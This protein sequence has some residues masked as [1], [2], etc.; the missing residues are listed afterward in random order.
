MS[1]DFLSDVG[2]SV[3]ELDLLGWLGLTEEELSMPRGSADAEGRHFGVLDLLRQLFGAEQ[4]GG[5]PPMEAVIGEAKIR[6]HQEA[7]IGEAR[8][9][10]DASKNAANQA[11]IDETIMNNQ[12]SEED[13]AKNAENIRF[14]NDL[15][16]S[17]NQ[18]LI[19]QM[20]MADYPEPIR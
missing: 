2:N 10:D 18:R 3:G 11:M 20:I 13:E 16:N 14:Q 7:V 15:K 6:P 9:T 19:D 12:P 17:D 8:F 4:P 5:N 1:D